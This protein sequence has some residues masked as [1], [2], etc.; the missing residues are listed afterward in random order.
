MWLHELRPKRH[1]FKRDNLDNHSRLNSQ[2][3]G[4][5]LYYHVLSTRI[6]TLIVTSAPK[7]MRKVATLSIISEDPLAKLLDKIGYDV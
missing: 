6:F 2:H 7:I 5:A 4:E 1:V 3:N